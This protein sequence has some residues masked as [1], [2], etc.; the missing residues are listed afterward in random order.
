MVALVAVVA[1]EPSATAF[2]KE[3]FALFPIEI[4]FFA[5]VATV[6][7][8]SIAV[9]SVALTVAVFPKA[10]LL[11]AST[12]ALVPNAVP[13]VPALVVVAP[14]PI[15]CEEAAFASVVAS[16]IEILPAKAL[17]VPL[18]ITLLSPIRTFK[19]LVDIAPFVAEP[20]PEMT[21]RIGPLPPSTR[22]AS[23]TPSVVPG[24]TEPS[25][26]PMK[27]IDELF[28]DLHGSPAR[29]TPSIVVVVV[30]VEVKQF[31]SAHATGVNKPIVVTKTT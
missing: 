14:A 15:A 3:V 12:F 22:T 30:K 5:P 29:F 18:P 6:A 28:A 31:V 13:L 7:L 11:F 17:S 16:P 23:E 4:P 2:A 1:P 20:T 24:A 25:A 26:F 21:L 9:P 8:L 19:L 27:V 10:E